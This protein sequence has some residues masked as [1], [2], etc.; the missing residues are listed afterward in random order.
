MNMANE[1]IFERFSYIVAR[2]FACA[3]VVRMGEK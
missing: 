1:L 3:I 2:F